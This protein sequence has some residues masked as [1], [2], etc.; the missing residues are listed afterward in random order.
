MA[1]Y[2]LGC[3]NGKL[4]TDDPRFNS[5]F[6]NTDLEYQLRQRDITKLVFAGLTTNTCLESTARYAR[7]L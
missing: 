2:S 4:Y 3:E 1:F 7:E 6:A 5:S